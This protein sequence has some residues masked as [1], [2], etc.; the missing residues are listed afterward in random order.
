MAS[1]EHLSLST[2]IKNVH[3]KLRS[4][5]ESLGESVAW[6]NHL[7]AKGDLQRYSVAMHNLATTYWEENTATRNVSSSD[8]GKQNNR[9]EWAVS[10]CLGYFGGGD[11]HPQCP[12]RYQRE[13]E[14]RIHQAMIDAGIE[15]DA[16]IAELWT[17]NPEDGRLRLLDVGSCYN[18]FE[19]YADDFLV[20][21]IDIAP[22]AGTAVKECD[23]LAARVAV[24][25]VAATDEN[26]IIS[27]FQANSYDVVV[28]SLLLEYLPT[29]GQRIACC[30]KAYQ[31]LRPEGVLVV[32]TPDSK[33]VGANAKL[34]KNWRYSLAGIGFSRI[35][36]EKLEHITCMVFRKAVSCAVARRWAE[37]HREAYMVDGV[38][39]PQ[40]YRLNEG[41]QNVDES[42]KN[43]NGD[44]DKNKEC[45][46]A[47]NVA[48][49]EGASEKE[50]HLLEI[51]VDSK[52]AKYD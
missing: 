41:A 39:I 13:R 25:A 20:T 35:R 7:Q 51:E 19:K 50:D 22:A 14:L 30:E 11:E 3:Q 33:H 4:E 12:L 5:T 9:I 37:L 49:E 44:D 1:A 18:P 47:L 2:V 10:F 45:G 34:M 31:V 32:I 17:K 24:D 23:F 21:A 26:Q 38:H 42:Q 16:T 52:K 48:T 6:A 40:D 15:F 46:H 28:F 36:I 29:S 8:T 43:G 27:T